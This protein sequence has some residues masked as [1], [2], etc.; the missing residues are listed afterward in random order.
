MRKYGIRTIPSLM[1]ELEAADWPKQRV[2][3]CKNNELRAIIAHNCDEEK[4]HNAK[5]DLHIRRYI[6]DVG[7]VTFATNLLK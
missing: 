6:H 2:D 4:Q 7:D 3:V 1:K 5:I